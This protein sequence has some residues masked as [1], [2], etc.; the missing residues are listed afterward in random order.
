MSSV[1]VYRMGLKDRESIQ[2]GDK[3]VAADGKSP[4]E[5][6][7]I[8]DVTED[9]YTGIVRSFGKVTRIPLSASQTLEFCTDLPLKLYSETQG[10]F[11]IRFLTSDLSVAT[12]FFP[13]R[14]LPGMLHFWESLRSKRHRKY[15][16]TAAQYANLHSSARNHLFLKDVSGTWHHLTLTDP[17]EGAHRLIRVE[18]DRRFLGPDR[19]ILCQ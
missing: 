8:D 10:A 2:V 11:Q 5:V 14:K 3:L 15:K 4:R 12:K 1:I 13:L 9:V 17:V 7:A 6:V 19:I 16:I 18:K